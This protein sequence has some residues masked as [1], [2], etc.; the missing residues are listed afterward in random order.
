[1]ELAKAS[2]QTTCLPCQQAW[3]PSWGQRG[4]GEGWAQGEAGQGSGELH[5]PC[6]TPINARKVTYVA[7]YYTG[8]REEGRSERDLGSGVYRIQ[9]WMNWDGGGGGRQIKGAWITPTQLTIW[10]CCSVHLWKVGE[11]VLWINWVGE[12]IPDGEKSS[13]GKTEASGSWPGACV[14][15]SSSIY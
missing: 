1:M 15:Y 4:A 9:W 6:G 8:N 2:L 7:Q 13:K 12:G 10:W 3:A 5:S 11:Q 14:T